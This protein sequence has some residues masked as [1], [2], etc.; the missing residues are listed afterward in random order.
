MI[1]G[2]SLMSWIGSIIG[3]E[4]G[5]A[6]PSRY[7]Q[8]DGGGQDPS[9]GRIRRGHV[10]RR[11]GGKVLVKDLGHT[12]AASFRAHVAD[13]GH[14]VPAGAP[15]VRINI[16]GRNLRRGRDR[17]HGTAE[18]TSRARINRNARLRPRYYRARRKDNSNYITSVIC[19]TEPIRPAGRQ[20]G[21]DAGKHG[22]RQ[23]CA[24]AQAVSRRTGDAYVAC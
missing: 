9:P 11:R 2:G 20:I 14:H 21:D 1:R 22:P 7:P 13:R 4:S 17:G 6:A 10:G 8:V 3:R 24:G 16:P 18:H 19:V 15:P 5:A 12:R 23:R